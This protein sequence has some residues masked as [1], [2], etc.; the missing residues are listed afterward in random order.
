MNPDSIA[1]GVRAA[2]AGVDQVTELRMFG[3]IGFMLKGNLIAG[4]SQ[5]GL[6]LRVGKDLEAEALARPGVRPMEM[7]GR[8]MVGYVYVDPSGLDEAAIRAWLHLA[9]PYVQTLPAKAK[10]ARKARPA[11]ARTR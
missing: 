1:D 6:L 8:R 9:V 11:K 2:L 7:R 10:K 3:G 4:T 5:R